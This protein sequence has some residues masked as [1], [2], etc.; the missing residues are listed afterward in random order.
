[1]MP[2]IDGLS[3]CRKLRSRSDLPYIYVVL[4]TAKDKQHD[5]I[6]AFEA[7]SDDFLAK[8]FDSQE[9]RVRLQTGIRILELQEQLV[10]ASTR[11]SLTGVL[12]RG[13][14]LQALGRE[15]AR[16]GRKA[17]PL[18]IILADLDYFKR[19]NDKFGHLAGDAVLRESALGMKSC[20]RPYDFIGRYGGEEFLMILP[21]L[22]VEAV[23]HKAEQIRIQAARSLPIPNGET[24]ISLSLGVTVTDKAVTSEQLIH[25]ADQALYRA[26][27]KGRNRVEADP[28]FSFAQLRPETKLSPSAMSQI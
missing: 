24:S 22:G 13:A 16:V 5:L 12:N 19:I 15:L 27:E 11:D 23:C 18:G 2:G 3:I 1:M 9:L 17:D 10:V 28:E 7:G 4:L 6:E 21:G 25:A 8:P 26:K 14:I 20:L